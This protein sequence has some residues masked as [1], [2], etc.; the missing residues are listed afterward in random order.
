MI[1]NVLKHEHWNASCVR[2][3]DL[4]LQFFSFFFNF[5]C[6]HGYAAGFVTVFKK[7]LFQFSIIFCFWFYTAQVTAGP[8]ILHPHYAR[9]FH[10]N[11]VKKNQKNCK[12]FAF[13]PT[14]MAGVWTLKESLNYKRR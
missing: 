11:R 6:F 2:T 12:A 1:S 10:P 14:P 7:I 9:V 13:W 4:F 5:W 8:P 3:Y